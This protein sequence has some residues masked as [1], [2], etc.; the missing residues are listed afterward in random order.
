MREMIHKDAPSPPMVMASDTPTVLNCQPS[1]P[2]FSTAPLMILPKSS[3]VP[4]R[5]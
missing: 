5:Q 1:M 2:C 3:T 4:L